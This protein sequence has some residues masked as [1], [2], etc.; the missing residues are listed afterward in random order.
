MLFGNANE[1]LAAY[2]ATEAAEERLQMKAEIES[3]LSLSL[4]D[5]ELQDILLNKIDC[6]YYYPNEW[7]S[8]EE[9]LKHIC[10]QMN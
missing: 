9:W 2:K 1:T 10:N 4:S 5:D 6:S 3:L 7:S 8:S